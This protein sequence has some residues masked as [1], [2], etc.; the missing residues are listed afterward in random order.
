M[1]L[2]LPRRAIALGLATSVLFLSVLVLDVTGALPADAIPGRSVPIHAVSTDQYTLTGSNGTDWELVDPRIF[3]QTFRAPSDGKVLIEANAD[4]WTETEGVNQELAI[5]FFAGDYDI[6]APVVGW[7]E[8]GGFGGTFSPNAATVIATS[9]VTQGVKYTAL[10]AW[11][12]N[13]PTT[14]TIHIGAG[15]SPTFSPTTLTVEFNT[16][17]NRLKE[18]PP[19]GSHVQ[20]TL[21]GS[22]GTTWQPMGAKLAKTFT[23]TTGGKALLLA[24]ADLFTDKAGVNQ[25]IGIQVTSSDGVYQSQIVGWKES[26][27][28]AG[29]FSPNA[30]AVIVAVD[31]QPA[32]EYAIQ[33]V[34]KSNI[35]TTGTIYAGARAHA[36]FS[37]TSLTIELEPTPPTTSSSQAQ[38]TLGSSDGA[39]W[40]VVD[41]GL[42]TTLSPPAD[43]TALLMANADL[44]TEQAGINQD[45]AILVSSS[46]GLLTDSVVAWK[47]SGGFA[48]TFSPNAAGIVATMPLLAGVTYTYRLG[49]KSNIPS[50]MPIHIGAG[51]RAP[52]SPT[53]LT[54]FAF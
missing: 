1:V 47:E 54:T 22:N 53:T 43:G 45:L 6:T 37:P 51:P 21:T 49:W 8:S 2:Q 7:K 46:D 32:V 29:T 15:N 17:P 13:K 11:R 10:L 12:T 36:P 5:L 38:Y 42:S 18:A 9:D 20:Y 16:S 3:Q 48:G 39:T 41:P 24:N 52:F 23:P 30:A 31:I 26:G 27:G 19:G 25:D 50:T 44:W 34:W 40:Q 35:P 14:G 4:M 28:F 33:L